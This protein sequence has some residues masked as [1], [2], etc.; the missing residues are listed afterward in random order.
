[1]AENAL[2]TVLPTLNAEQGGVISENVLF[3]HDD[4]TPIDLSLGRAEFRI[5]PY[6]QW[7]NTVLKKEGI[8]SVSDKSL[9]TFNF[10]SEDTINLAAMVYEYMPIAVYDNNG[11]PQNYMR[12]RGILNLSPMIK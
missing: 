9:A 10:A 6:G 3:K 8:I 2:S 11:K 7:D 12:G 5:C 4:G 1:M